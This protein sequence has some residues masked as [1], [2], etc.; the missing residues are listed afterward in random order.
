M[1]SKKK[2]FRGAKKVSVMRDR[3]D[4]LS[5]NLSLVSARWR[6]VVEK[7]GIM[8]VMD[9]AL[10][11]HQNAFV[12]AASSGQLEEPGSFND[13]RSVIAQA[14][15]LMVMGRLITLI[16]HLRDALAAA[17]AE[18]A[19][20]YSFQLAL[21]MTEWQ[22]NNDFSYAAQVGKKTLES[23]QKA[24]DHNAAEHNKKI[25]RAA[26]L[27]NLADAIWGKH[28]TWSQNDVAAEILKRHSKYQRWK[29]GTIAKLIKKPRKAAK[30]C[31]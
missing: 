28:P 31:A 13:H 15:T 6:D 10:D 27:Q 29:L 11:F 14:S 4:G 16:N 25:A 17:N 21:S 24:T 18:A 23:F 7:G 8:P 3:S 1:A 20:G 2:M 19:A 26:A 12:S 9:I 22:V 30:P 5:L